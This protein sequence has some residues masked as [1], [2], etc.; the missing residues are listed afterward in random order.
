[1]HRR[2]R[3]IEAS[4]ARRRRRSEVRS[5]TY[6]KLATVELWIPTAISGDERVLRGPYR[7]TCTLREHLLTQSFTAFREKIRTDARGAEMVA[8]PTAYAGKNQLGREVADILRRNIVQGVRVENSSSGASQATQEER[9]RA[10]Y[11]FPA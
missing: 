3:R 4:C 5:I 7:S 9:W 11:F 6:L 10:S 8:D 1:M 2:G